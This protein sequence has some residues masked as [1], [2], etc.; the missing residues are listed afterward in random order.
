MKNFLRNTTFAVVVGLS[1]S[2]N[3][4]ISDVFTVGVNLAAAQE[5]KEKKAKQEKDTIMK[6][7]LVN[8]EHETCKQRADI[9]QRAYLLKAK[10]AIHSAKTTSKN[11]YI[12]LNHV[13]EIDKTY[14]TYRLA[15]TEAFI[16]DLK[17]IK[18]GQK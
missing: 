9:K 4:F 6:M 10:K 5:L 8:K 1:S 12:Y 2:A 13:A 14:E 7:E 16:K 18:D 3:A 11:L 15:C 17:Q